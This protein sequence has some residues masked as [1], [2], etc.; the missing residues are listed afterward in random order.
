MIFHPLVAETLSEDDEE[1]NARKNSGK[2]GPFSAL[3]A[4]MW[5]QDLVSDSPVRYKGSLV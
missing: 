2:E 4:S 1:T 5:P 3:T